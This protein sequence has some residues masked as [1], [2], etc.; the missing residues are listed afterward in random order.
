MCIAILNIKNTLPKEYIENSWE[1]NNQGAGMLYNLNGKLT[2][3]KT[4]DKQEFINHYYLIR[5]KTKGKIVLHFRI[6]TSGFEKY[7]N[8]HPFLVNDSLGFVH[9][10]IISGLGNNQHSDT[11]KFNEML[12]NFSH[13]FINCNQTK[14]FIASY[15]GSSKL[16]FLDS[17]DNHNIINEKMG[18]WSD[19]NWFSNDSYKES[20]DFYYYGNQKVGKSSV[21]SDD[22]WDVPSQVFSEQEFNEWISTFKNV[23]EDDI[24]YA[25]YMIGSSRYSEEFYEAI[26]NAAYEANT[27]TFS[28]ILEN[29][30]ANQ[31]KYTC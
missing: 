28:K 27:L 7:T 9:N 29:V 14:D 31:F 12:Q 30:W 1:N 10:G 11:Y 13:D 23:K 4:Y 25:E 8:L 5:S 20:L 19:G 22:E 16:V 21:W 26:E 2:V 18:H 17:S 3:F 15:I 6:A 24:S